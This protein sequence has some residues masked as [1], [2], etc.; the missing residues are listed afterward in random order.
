[1]E[2]SIAAHEPPQHNS[3]WPQ[4]VSQLPQWARVFSSTH[5]PPQ[6][7]VPS[8]QRKPQPPQLRSS[9][10]TQAPSQHNCPAAQ[11]TPHEPQLASSVFTLAQVPPQQNSPGSHAWKQ[12]PQWLALVIG[13]HV[14][15]VVETQQRA[16][17]SQ[18]APQAPQ[19]SSLRIETHWPSQQSS[20]ALHALP[21]APQCSRPVAGT[22]ASLQQSSPATQHKSPPRQRVTHSQRAFSGM[23]AKRSRTWQHFVPSAQ[24]GTSNHSSPSRGHGSASL[25]QHSQK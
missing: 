15:P 8:R 5:S 24:Q 22:H 13:S 7:T 19:C 11:E 9:L 17:G 20:L 18:R 23:Q 25:G 21:Q 6:Q 10:S 2:A 14:A 3:F 16:P 1:L 12:R 4:R